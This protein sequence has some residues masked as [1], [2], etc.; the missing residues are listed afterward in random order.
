[1]DNKLKNSVVG[2]DETGRSICKDIKISHR[3]QRGSVTPD[4]PRQRILAKKLRDNRDRNEEDRRNSTY[5][6]HDYGD[7]GSESPNLHA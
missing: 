6:D 5:S 1:M 2:D 4:T 3:R 7:K